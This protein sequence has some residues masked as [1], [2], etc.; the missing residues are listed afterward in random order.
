MNNNITTTT[1]TSIS[2]NNS[3]RYELYQD[4]I[5]YVFEHRSTFPVGLNE[6]ENRLISS[7]NDSDILTGLRERVIDTIN[8]NGGNNLSLFPEF[9]QSINSDQLQI[10]YDL[11]SQSNSDNM[12][13]P[14]L[15]ILNLFTNFDTQLSIDVVVRDMLVNILN[16]QNSNQLNV[17][18]PNPE[19]A[20]ITENALTSINEISQNHLNQIRE[21]TNN[22]QQDLNERSR[23]ALRQ[24]RLNIMYNRIAQ[25]FLA[26]PQ[27][28]L[29]VASA[30]FDTIYNRR[31]SNSNNRDT[32]Q[33]T[34]RNPN[35]E[36]NRESPNL[37]SI[38]I[39]FYDWVAGNSPQPRG[40]NN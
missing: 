39:D 10:M 8:T 32:G 6:T 11:L 23:V 7:I 5:D 25:F 28:T 18:L 35:P 15:T 16:V 31:G 36:P 27:I 34:R 40:G 30:I 4:Q 19:I 12:F 38:L 21:N 3:S 22:F 14:A 37:R 13:F 9:I 17:I 20:N 29:T 33:I 26:R 1:I 24:I 2:N